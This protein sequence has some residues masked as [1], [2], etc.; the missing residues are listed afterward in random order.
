MVNGGRHRPFRETILEM[1]QVDF[2]DFPL[3]P[4]TTLA[5]LKAAAH[6]CDDVL[7]QCAFLVVEQRG[8]SEG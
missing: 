1:Q 5:Y 7:R 4:R 2:G 3:E 6:C 8:L